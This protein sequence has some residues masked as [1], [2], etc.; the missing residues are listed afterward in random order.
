[1]RLRRFRNSSVSEGAAPEPPLGASPQTPFLGEGACSVFFHSHVDETG[2]GLFPFRRLL[3]LLRNAPSPVVLIRMIVNEPRHLYHNARHGRQDA[4][5]R[6][7]AS[8]APTHSRHDSC[9]S[10]RSS[11]RCIRCAFRAPARSCISAHS[12]LSD[13]HPPTLLFRS[14]LIMQNPSWTKRSVYLPLFFVF[15]IPSVS[16]LV[17]DVKAKQLPLPFGWMARA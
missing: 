17:C 2:P 8:A 5:V 15:E 3:S 1:M 6:Y 4:V 10:G 12:L 13:P 11:L 9:I 14:C 7:D 16:G